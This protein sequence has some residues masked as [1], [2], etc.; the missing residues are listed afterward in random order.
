MMLASGAAHIRGTTGRIGTRLTIVRGGVGIRRAAVVV[1]REVEVDRLLRAVAAAGARQTGCVFLV[2]EG[3][4][5]KTRLLAEAVAAARR[6][7]LGVLSGRAP[8]T[9]PLPYS[10]LAE[11]LRSWLRGHERQS[12]A[13]AFD[14][15]LRLVLPEWTSAETDTSELSEVQLRLLALEGVVH[16]VREIAAANDGAVLVLD[17]LH[18]ADP[19]SLE[20][21]RYLATAAI[22]GVVVIGALRSGE[23]AL[24]DELTRALRGD[25]TADVIA[26]EPLGERAVSELVA[27]LLDA[28]PPDALVADIVARTDGVP[29]LVEE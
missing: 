8:I 26:L 2:G 22:D 1:G 9:T 17:D 4:V 10:V 25:G 11:A 5:G 23:A 27:A 29:L 18:A 6:T 16:L 19:D 28:D 7:G 15:G 20:A 13:S 3:G 12:G 21:T 14:R 24:A